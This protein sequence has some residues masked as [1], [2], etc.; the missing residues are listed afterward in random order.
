MSLCGYSELLESN[1]ARTGIEKEAVDAAV[2]L[3]QVAC[4]IKV[5]L[6]SRQKEKQTHCSGSS[7]SSDMG[8]RIWPMAVGLGTSSFQLL[9]PMLLGAE[10]IDRFA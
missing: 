4:L 6:P 7:A 5:S 1:Q 2:H 8:R 3:I 10:L 9:P